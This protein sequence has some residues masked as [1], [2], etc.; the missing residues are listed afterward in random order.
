MLCCP[1]GKTMNAASNGPA[2]SPALPP[3]WK[4]DCASPYFPPDA[5]RT[6]REDSG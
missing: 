3:N 5:M 4:S 1:F 2:A 6:T